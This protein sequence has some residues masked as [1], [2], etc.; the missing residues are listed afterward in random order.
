MAQIEISGGPHAD[1]LT[2]LLNGVN[3]THSLKRLVINMEAGKINEATLTVVAPTPKLD[4][5]ARIRAV[6]DAARE[7]VT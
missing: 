5:Q 2:V 4:I 6:F 1:D 7:D 3:V